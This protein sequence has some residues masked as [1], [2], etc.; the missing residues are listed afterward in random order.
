[1]ADEPKP[2]RYE[3]N[4]GTLATIAAILIALASFYSSWKSDTKESVTNQLDLD[5]ALARATR[6]SSWVDQNAWRIQD[7][8]SDHS[9]SLK[10]LYHKHS[11]DE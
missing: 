6:A 5:S 10:H 9:D 4:L 8:L 11:P 1:M 3:F 2:R 7:R